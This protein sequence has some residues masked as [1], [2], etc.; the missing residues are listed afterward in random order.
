MNEPRA[1]AMNPISRFRSDIGIRLICLMLLLALLPMIGLGI[2][3]RSSLQSSLL[4]SQTKSLDDL[5]DTTAGT[6]DAF[7]LS[8]LTL[9]E[10]ASQ[11]D[12]VVLYASNDAAGRS[13]YA[14]GA[15]NQLRQLVRQ[16]ASFELAG[17]TD[18]RGRILLDAA[19]AGLGSEED[20]DISG[21][22]FFSAAAGGRSFIS[23]PAVNAAA[24][25]SV[26]Y[27]SAPIYQPGQTSR[28]TG[29]L[30]L[31]VN[32]DALQALLNA[33]STQ[34]G[35]QTQQ[36][37]QLSL[38]DN[39][40]VVI[41]QS[42]APLVLTDNQL[43]LRGY[44]AIGTTRLDEIKR[45][46]RFGTDNVT[47]TP[48]SVSQDFLGA[49]GTADN[50]SAFVY[51]L[52]GK[53]NYSSITKL[54]ST[55]WSL[56]STQ[57][58]A[59]ILAPV[60]QQT[61]T[62]LLLGLL[63]AAVAAA[64]AFIAARQITRPVG[65]MERVARRISDGDYTSRM[66]VTGTDQFA[67]LGTTVNA[68][69]DQIVTNARLQEEQNAEL[70]TQI[71]RL[72]EEVS[73]V[74]EG[75]LTV[76]AEVNDSALGAVA[77]SF[78][79]MITELRQVI[80]RVNGATQQVSNSTDEILTTTDNL[81]RSAEQ[82]AARIADTSTAIEEMAVSI[83]QVSEN[84][85]ISAQV[86]RSARDAA[87]NGSQA[88]T[89]TVEGMVRIRQQVQ[90]TAKKIKRL[91]ESSQEIGQAVQLIEEIARRTNRLAL[92]AA[93]QAAMA[94][95]HGKGF[96]V[97]AEEVRRLA[98]RTT[99]ATT[100]IAELVGAIQ[101]ETA[102]AVIAMEDGTREVVGGS[103][104]ADEAGRSLDSIDQIVGQLAELIE[105]I[106][107]AADQQARASAGIARAMSELSTVTQGT[108]VGSQQAA[109]SVASLATLADDLRESV[110]TFRL[111]PEHAMN[112]MNGSNGHNGHGYGLPSASAT[113]VAS[114]QHGRN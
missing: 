13:Q 8:T 111:D 100:Q 28:V 67:S 40:G 46:K 30:R 25:Q 48:L 103:R 11:A 38:V 1:R 108:A 87:S 2:V 35:Q 77:D 66:P 42:G 93:I 62:F 7:L 6:L 26:F 47:V 27:L 89:A 22:E 52:D 37:L 102:G 20:V 3:G 54:G 88:V 50:G 107:L 58:E 36:D 95:E 61:R 4:S 32:A 19:S 59:T 79:Y 72:L 34:G 94:G 39:D 56:V 80:G 91:G 105:A 18:T 63:F 53:R 101:S 76:E 16:N 21:Q 55:G 17:L 45:T 24:K 106:S 44:R 90:E 10:F 31:R 14:L 41:Q 78:N 110:A 70:Q 23:V 57:S 71:V 96:A 83:Q 99:A 12:A 86:A 29:V 113:L 68:M 5:N 82:Q 9:V 73:T 85:A 64:F 74:A 84:A 49:L 97:V 65:Q 81:S 92:N 98:E 33:H 114:G 112:G 43:R 104:L 60:N 109:A 75:D 51:T 69:V 15:L